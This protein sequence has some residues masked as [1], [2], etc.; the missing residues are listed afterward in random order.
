MKALYKMDNLDKGELLC[1]LFPEEMGNIQETVK[2]Q[3]NYFLQNEVLFRKGWNKKGLI[4]ADFW[5]R[6]VQDVHKVIEKHEDKLLKNPRW[7]AD[8]FFD[9]YKSIFVI[10]C[11]IEYRQTEECTPD[12]KET[13]HLL[14]GSEPLLTINLN[15]E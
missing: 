14:F 3:C 1:K 6:L 15:D 4:T 13:I 12:L 5:Y 7:F 9:G 11:L 8:H 10:H 2:Q